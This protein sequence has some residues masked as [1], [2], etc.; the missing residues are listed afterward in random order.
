MVDFRRAVLWQLNLGKQ[1]TESGCLRRMPLVWHKGKKG[2]S[3]GR[4]FAPLAQVPPLLCPMGSTLLFLDCLP[5]DMK[6][7]SVVS[8]GQVLAQF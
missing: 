6:K 8:S 5:F 2:R 7:L 1:T 3:R 4:G